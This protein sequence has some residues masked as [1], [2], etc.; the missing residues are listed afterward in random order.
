VLSV[1]QPANI[2]LMTR[3]DKQGISQ[4]VIQFV[5]KD[6]EDGDVP[7]KKFQS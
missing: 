2:I 7:S 4:F 1:L 3:M 5:I 6:Q